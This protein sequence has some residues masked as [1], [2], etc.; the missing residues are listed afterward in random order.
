[1]LQ[2]ADIKRSL[3]D[4]RRALLEQ[5]TRA[6]DDIRW[7]D[8]HVSPEVEE[9]AQEENLSRVLGRLDDRGREEIGDLDETVLRIERGD[10]GRCE[11]CGEEIPLARLEAL[12]TATC[13]VPCAEARERPR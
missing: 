8:T 3:L 11:D 7:L 12:P 1:M 2:I 13:C 4:R 9:E 10:Y 6:E 5:V